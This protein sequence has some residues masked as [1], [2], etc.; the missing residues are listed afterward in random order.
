[1][2]MK[3]GLIHRGERFAYTIYAGYSKSYTSSLLNYAAG[4]NFLVEVYEDED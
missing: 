2:S 3:K 1:M 4:T